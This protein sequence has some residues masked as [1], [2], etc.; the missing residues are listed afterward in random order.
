M[1][2]TTRVTDLFQPSVYKPCLIGILLMIFQQFSGMN[3]V[4]FNAAEIFRVVDPNFDQLVGV[5][6]INVVQVFMT[7]LTIL[8]PTHSY[9]YKRLLSQKGG[10]RRRFFSVGGET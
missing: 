4:L 3:A 8:V 1:K 5:V 2:E 10:R 9:R 7:K 6:L